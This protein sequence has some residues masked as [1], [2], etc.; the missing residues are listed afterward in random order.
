MHL[1]S[2]QAL[3]KEII[4]HF[5]YLDP[6]VKVNNCDKKCLYV[7]QVLT[8][9]LIWH[10]F[11]D[12]VRE[13]DGDSV[14]TYWKFFILVFKV[15]RHHNYFKES[16]I[17]LLQYHFLLPQ[18]QAEQL[19]WCRFVNYRGRVGGNVSCELHLEHL[20]CRLKDI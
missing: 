12:A 19:K 14:L 7:M 15:T 1:E 6:N 18:R 11:D 3:A 9:G 8:L 17:L 13:G 2:A 10:G 5:L 16:V 4:V 20:N